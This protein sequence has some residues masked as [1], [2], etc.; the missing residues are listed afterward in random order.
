MP[1]VHL[2]DPCQLTPQVGHNRKMA[3]ISAS[4]KLVYLTAVL[5]LHQDCIQH[6]TLTHA[7]HWPGMHCCELVCA[8]NTQATSVRCTHRQ[9]PRLS[10]GGCCHATPSI[11]YAQ[12]PT[13]KITPLTPTRQ[14]AL[15]YGRPRSSCTRGPIPPL[16]H[17]IPLPLATH[18]PTPTST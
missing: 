6:H 17:S 8:L 7:S 5:G 4:V 10:Y 9:T 2:P 14:A 1:W 18:P 12:P 13:G 11:M 15:H 16:L 3:L